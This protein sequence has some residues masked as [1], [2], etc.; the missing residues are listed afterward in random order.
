MYKTFTELFDDLSSHC[1][2]V[3][4]PFIKVS[5]L[6]QLIAS[7]NTRFDFYLSDLV[8]RTARILWDLGRSMFVPKGLLI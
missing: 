6:S 8:R 2:Q 3:I 4:V 1:L 5:R 7:I